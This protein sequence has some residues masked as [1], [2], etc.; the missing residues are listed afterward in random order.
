MVLAPEHPLVDEIIPSA[1]WPE[2]THEVWKGADAAAADSPA[3]AVAAYRRSTSRKSDV[4][5][6][7]DDRTKT[8]VF[9]GA[10]AAN[11]LNGNPIPVFVADYVLMGYG[12]GAI[13]AV[14]AGD[15]ARLGLRHRVRAADRRCL[16]P[17]GRPTGRHVAWGTR[18]H[19]D[20]RGRHQLVQR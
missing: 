8:G 14:P 13:M 4:E 17:W 9:T 19:R 20:G 12:T 11:P 10:F 16:A 15:R 1:G 3:A 5:R 2:G 18:L 6:Q 7:M